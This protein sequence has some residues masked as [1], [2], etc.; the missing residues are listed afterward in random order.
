MS[1]ELLFSILTIL[2]LLIPQM[3]T[4]LNGSFSLALVFAI[5][6]AICIAVGR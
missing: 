3:N 4:T 2:A 1:L 6:T 5:I